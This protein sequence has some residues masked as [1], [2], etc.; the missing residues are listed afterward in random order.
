M[1]P[2]QRVGSIDVRKELDAVLLVLLDGNFE[3][4]EIYGAQRA[5]VIEA[6]SAPGSLTRNERG[7]LAES[8]FKSI[9]KL[10]WHR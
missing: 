1:K 4:L 2:R 8:R 6:L 10:R 3:A 7:A 9:A 5:P